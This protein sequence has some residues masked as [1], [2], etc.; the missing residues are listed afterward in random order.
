M[1]GSTVLDLKENFARRFTHKNTLAFN[2]EI[3]TLLNYVGKN[4]V[5]FM[6]NLISPLKIES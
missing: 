3:K 2:L 4:K 1:R 5:G 6:V